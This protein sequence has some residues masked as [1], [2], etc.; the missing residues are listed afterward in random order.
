MA[1][2]GHE[3]TVFTT[4]S[5]Q[6]ED[7]DVEVNKPI[8]FNGVNV[9]YFKR[10]ELVKK[11]FAAIPYLAQSA[12]FGFAPE[13][14]PALLRTVPQVDIVHTQLPFNYPTVATGRAARRI[15]KPLFYNQR[16]DFDPKRLL[17]RAAKKRLFLRLMEMPNLRY[18]S[19]LI[20]L[21][22]Y[23]Q[24]SFRALG[25]TNPVHVIPNGI[26][27]EKFRQESTGETGQRLGI[28]P[29]S[30]VILFLGRLHSVK[31]A[32]KL[33]EAFLRIQSQF[34]TSVLV[35]AG[36][37]EHDIE[38]KSKEIVKEAKL[39]HRVLFPGTVSGQD[40][41]DLLARADIFCLP[42][43]AEGFS[44]AVLEAMASHTAMLLSPGCYFPESEAAGASV[45]VEP[46]V[47]ELAK[48][49][50][51]LLADPAR[52]QLMADRG[53]SLVRSEYTWDSVVDKLLTVYKA[54]LPSHR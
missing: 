31:G 28:A 2:R 45:I 40:K 51:S 19:G 46:T 15:G 20:A 16:G 34:P 49:L 54:A 25:L 12:G 21:T 44:M 35:M 24:E 36:P 9:W 27:V 18:A 41:A 1:A 10:E 17:Y 3:V 6:N 37:D 13:L 48:A 32:D 26:H 7:L 22:T 8:E 53:L 47:E 29:D 30:K 14:K 38:L 33:L 39:E 50:S 4:N 43:D 5:N 23:E 11:Y 52:M 42:S